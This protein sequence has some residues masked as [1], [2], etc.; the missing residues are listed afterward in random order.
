M[1]M[2]W[3]GHKEGLKH[4]LDEAYSR[5]AKSAGV[6]VHTKSFADQKREAVE[7]MLTEIFER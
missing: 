7:K 4:L 1:L 3:I 2:N 6:M 5:G